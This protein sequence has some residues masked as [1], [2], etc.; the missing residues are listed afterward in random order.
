MAPQV[1]SDCINERV[2][3]DEENGAELA[4]AEEVSAGFERLILT[5]ESFFDKWRLAFA[6]CD[7]LLPFRF[8]NQ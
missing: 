1:V 7:F 6:F 5:R 3:A 4:K 2:Q 8:F